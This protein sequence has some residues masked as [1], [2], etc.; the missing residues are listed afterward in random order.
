M[1]AQ[2]SPYPVTF[3]IDWPET[4]NR[5]TVFFRGV[6]A[7]PHFLFLILYLIAF[8]FVLLVAWLVAVHGSVVARAV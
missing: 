4:R 6:L 5:V 3:E 1:T 2:S 8:W 7:I